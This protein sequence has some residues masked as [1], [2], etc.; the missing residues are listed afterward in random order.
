[1]PGG[2]DGYGELAN[3]H[4]HSR[5][6]QRHLSFGQIPTATDVEGRFRP[7]QPRTGLLGDIGNVHPMVEVAV[8]D[9]QRRRTME[10]G[11]REDGIH[12]RP[13]GLD[14]RPHEHSHRTTRKPAIDQEL[15][16]TIIKQQRA[17]AIPGHLDGPIFGRRVAVR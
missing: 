7:V 4:G 15:R 13:V 1:M 8:P 2:D 11:S 3:R 10:F 9:E 5:L 17:H 14:R 12:C 16:V 6:V